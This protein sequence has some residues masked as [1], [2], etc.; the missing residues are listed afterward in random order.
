MLLVDESQNG[1]RKSREEEERNSLL[2]SGIL[3][4]FIKFLIHNINICS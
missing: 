3:D 1:K 4:D 2:A